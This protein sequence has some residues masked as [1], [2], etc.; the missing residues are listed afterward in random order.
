[1][2]ISDSSGI[3][4]RRYPLIVLLVRGTVFVFA[5]VF[6]LVL[7]PELSDDDVSKLCL[8]VGQVLFMRNQCAKLSALNMCPQ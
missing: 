2:L 8:Q 4:M 5:S 7:E 6:A 1:M 3:S